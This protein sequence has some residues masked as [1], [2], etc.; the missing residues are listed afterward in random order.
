MASSRSQPFAELHLHLEGSI[1]AA[2]LCRL[3]PALSRADAEAIY[4]FTSFPD[5]LQA[6]KFIVLRLRSADDYRLAARELF[7]SLHAQGI[8]YAEIIHSAGVNLWRGYDA[9]AIVHALLEEGRRAPLQIRWILDAV[10]QFGGDHALAVAKLA[11]DF[12]GEDVVAFGVGGDETGAPASELQPAFQWARDA[13]LHLT[14]H[15]GETSNAANVWDALSLGVERIGHGIRAIEDPRLI[16]HLAEHQ[17]PLEISLTSNVKTGAVP[18]L[19]AHP[20]QALH[21]AGVP[22]ILNTDDPALFA[23]TLSAEFALASSA[24]GFTPEDLARLRENAFRYA[25]AYRES[26]ATAPHLP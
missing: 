15:A 23:T 11:A 26:P 18:S 2:L 22:L 5:F 8:V 12:A 17:I 19:A 16:Q 24:L 21:D 3:D 9:H 25:F 7:A 10:R 13:G 6:F 20:A 1:D 14:A 4:R